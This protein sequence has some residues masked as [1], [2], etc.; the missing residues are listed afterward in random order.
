MTERAELLERYKL[1]VAEY[2]AEVTL[3]HARQQ[4]FVTLNPAVAAFSANGNRTISVA[5]LGLAAA[6]SLVGIL[7]VWRSHGRYRQT[8]AVLLELARALGCE[9]D[10]QTTG[11][12]REARGEPRY[13]RGPR[14]VMALSVLLALYAVFDVVAIVAVLR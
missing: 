12:M 14:V 3:G 7:L 2:R 6:A 5:A 4:L 1:A 8:R 10:W 11:G 9:G 13:E